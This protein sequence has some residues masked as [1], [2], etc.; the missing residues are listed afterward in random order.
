MLTAV[1]NQAICVRCTI[2]ID[3]CPF[4]AILGS[5]G[6]QHHVLLDVCIGC[7]LCVEP[8]PVDCIEMVPLASLNS[9]FNKKQI[10]AN[11]KTKKAAK[12]ARINL[13]DAAKLSDKDT[14]QQDLIK[15]KSQK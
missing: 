4:D 7:K 8:C 11:A 10:V 3:A 14:I 2:C 13:Q 6:E 1:I 9:N 5:I 15:I 12:A